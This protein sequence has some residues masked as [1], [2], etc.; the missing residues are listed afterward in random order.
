MSPSVLQI[1]TEIAGEK[2]GESKELELALPLCYQKVKV[3]HLQLH[4]P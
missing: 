2:G 4:V 1:K 3:Q